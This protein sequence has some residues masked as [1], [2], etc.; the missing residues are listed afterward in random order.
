M[1]TDKP[2][3]I[4]ALED[5]I[6]LFYGATSIHQSEA[7]DWL[8]AAQHSFAAW[9]FSWDLMQ[10]G[11]S[12]EVQFYGATTLHA[13]LMKHWHELPKDSHEQLKQ[14]L[15]ETI[16]QFGGGPKVVLIRLC[17][18][19]SAFIVHMLRE[20]WP[21]AIEDVC[22]TFQNQQLPNLDRN[23]QTCVMMEVL[24]GIPEETNAIYTSVTRASLRGEVKK[25][26]P[27]VLQIV[28]NFL[29]SKCSSDEML[30]ENDMSTLTRATKCAS[31]W[32]KNGNVPIDSCHTLVPCLLKLINKCYWPN[33]KP[34]SVDDDGCM[35]GDENEL[36]ES[37][38]EALQ[39]IVVQQNAERYSNTA[40]GF[41]RQFLREL[42]PITKY[43]WRPNNLNE[44][45]SVGIYSLM[46]SSIECHSRFLLT[47]LTVDNSEYKELFSE[48]IAMCLECTSKPGVYPVEESCSTLVMG[49]WYML[50]DEVLTTENVEDRE[51]CI[52]T[53]KPLYKVL[54][55]ILVRKSQL[56]DEVSIEKWSSDDLET[57][58]CYRQDISD[59]LVYCFDVLHNELLHVLISL[60]DE[61]IMIIQ[62]NPANW[63]QLE[64]SLFSFYSVVE[65][66]DATEQIAI[67][68]L[69]GVLK[70][71]P[72]EKLNEK[73]L[74]TALETIGAYCEWLRDNPTYIPSA[75]ELLV[76]GLNSSMA[77]QATLGLKDLCR[78]CQPQLKP[79]A[80]YL[81]NACQQSFNSMQLKNTESVRLMFSVGKIMSMLPPENILPC[82]DKMI[83]PC[84]EELCSLCEAGQT[85]ESAKIRTLYCIQMI[86]T[87]F[88]SLN[89]KV[90]DANSD[91]EHQLQQQHPNSPQPLLIVM[92]KTMPI[93]S[94]VVEI[95]IKEESVIEAICNALRQSIINLLT[96]FKPMLQDTCCLIMSI[97]QTQRLAP[98]VDISKTC[99]LHF[100]RE[101]DSKEIMR[102]LFI[103]MCL[104]HIKEFEV[105]NFSFISDL[106][107]TFF[108]SCSQ[109]VKKNPLVFASPEIDCNKLLHYATIAMKMSVLGALKAAVQ[110]ISHFVAQSR[111]YPPMMAAVLDSRCGGENIICT[112]LMCIAATT[113]RFLVE[114]FADLFLSINKKYPQELIVW[115]QIFQRAEFPSNTISPEEKS[116]FVKNVIK[117]KVNKRLL[118]SHI[119]EFAVRSRGLIE[120]V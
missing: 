55:T 33:A 65:H 119:R 97:M 30:H 29:L 66:I 82:L 73:L 36:A 35:S 72:Y 100:Y 93:F 78:E 48:L 95:W 37:C 52:K 113:P 18:S 46:I 75:I 70:D 69:M 42:S 99:Y 15:L 63:I 31:A 54:A 109:I 10:P 4:K 26:A 6:I 88:L 118:Q 24:L 25:R 91:S 7:H 67:P 41:I 64:A 96:D 11:K 1:E 108:S 120:N 74:G 39:T 23:T 20:E 49:F 50:Q 115:L 8:N 12:Q 53:L 44:D 56:P 3:D 60:L 5:A 114:H 85:T 104:F 43:E 61:S 58:R 9:S 21:T 77:S 16:V 117:E 17:I 38:L 89:T 22:N 106:V 47:A 62:S 83:S 84:F 87:I 94:K 79:Y 71:I 105:T 57:F 111:G 68:K 40:V 81:L 51:K 14:K 112:A 59:T 2:I 32:I 28:E 98:A 34:S 101:D 76:R 107:E 86:S 90:S 103:Q 92:Q 102:Q 110:F 27:F 19:L 80:E 13:K 116:Q 45:I